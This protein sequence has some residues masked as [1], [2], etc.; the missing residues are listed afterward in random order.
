MKSKYVFRELERAYKRRCP[1]SDIA[2][3]KDMPADVVDQAIKDAFI[4]LDRDIV[5]GGANAALGDRFLNDAMSELSPSYSG[6]SALVGLYEHQTKLLR[7][8]CTGDSKYISE[9]FSPPLASDNIECHS[10]PG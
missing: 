1:R 5:S 2:W 7:I 9:S 3:Y 4:S 10:F 8:A 6:S